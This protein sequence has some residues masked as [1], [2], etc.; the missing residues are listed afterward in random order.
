[1]LSNSVYLAIEAFI[2]FNVLPPEATS[3][4]EFVEK[5]D[6]LFDSLNSS[7]VKITERK[8]R[9]AISTSTGHIEF[10]NSCIAWIK[11]WKFKAPRQP[12]TIHRHP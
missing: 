1:M 2:A 10:L 7:C 11:S 8:M 6:Q 5:M 4:A 9:Y 3:M 12:T